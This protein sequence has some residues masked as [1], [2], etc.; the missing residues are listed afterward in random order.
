MHILLLTSG[1]EFAIRLKS[2]D[3]EPIAVFTSTSAS[4]QASHTVE[5]ILQKRKEARLCRLPNK[6]TQLD[7]ARPQ[8]LAVQLDHVGV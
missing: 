6:V 7:T 3:H 8:T 5:S 4:Q 2:T 1:K